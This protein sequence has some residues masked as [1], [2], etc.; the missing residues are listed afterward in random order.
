MLALMHAAPTEAL[1]GALTLV[2]LCAALIVASLGIIVL[3]DVP[4]QIWRHLKKLRMSK[5]DVRQEHKESEGDPHI[6]ARLRQHPRAMA[7]RRMM[8]EGPRAELVI[9]PPT[10]T[11]LVCRTSTEPRDTQWCQ[12]EPAGA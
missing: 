10:L 2:A 9:A 11:P 8:N 3:L 7:R 5:E 1:V 4:W 6:K 12:K